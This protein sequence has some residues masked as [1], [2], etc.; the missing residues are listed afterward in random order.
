MTKI[1][2]RGL[3]EEMDA[4][5]RF[6]YTL[7]GDEFREFCQ[8][9]RGGKQS[10]EELSMLVRSLTDPNPWRVILSKKQVQEI[11]EVIKQSKVNIDNILEVIKNKAIN[12]ELISDDA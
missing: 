7:Y 4:I 5:T 8:K 11:V 9:E 12:S 6:C 1:T 10:L 2:K 3:N